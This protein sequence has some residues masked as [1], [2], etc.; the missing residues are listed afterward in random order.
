ME[1]LWSFIKAKARRHNKWFG[2]TNDTNHHT[3]T[4]RHIDLIQ[5]PKLKPNVQLNK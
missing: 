5:F 3:D 1:L 2:K 4:Q